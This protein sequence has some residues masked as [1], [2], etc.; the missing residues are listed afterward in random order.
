[1][2]NEYDTIGDYLGE[3]CNQIVEGGVKMFVCNLS[4]KKKYVMGGEEV[5]N[6]E[7][8]EKAKDVILENSPEKSDLEG[9]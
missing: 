3:E 2:S 4:G 7:Y 8:S 1:M 9:E 6:I 5:E